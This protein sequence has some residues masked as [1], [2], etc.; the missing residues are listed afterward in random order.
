MTEDWL[1]LS[2]EDRW[3]ELRVLQKEYAR[4]PDFLYDVITGLMGFE[5]TPLQLDIALYLEFGPT[6]RMI[7][8]QRGQAKTTVTAAY[9]VWRLI[10]NPA[11]RILIVSAGDDM[12]TEIANW[13]IQIIMG[14]DEL[15]CMR[16]DRSHGD[17]ASVKAFDVH[18]VL[19][20]PEKS[21]SISCKGITSNLQG[22]RADILVAD[23]IESSKNSRTEL[24]REQLAHLTKDFS[25][26]C[27]TGDIIY[28]GTPQS[29]DSV[30]NGLASRGFDIRIWP[31]RYPTVQEQQNYGEFLA[32]IIKKAV[33]DDPSLRT[34]GGPLADR[35]QPT[36]PTLISEDVLTKK[37]IDQGKAYFQLQHMLDT[38]LMDKD[39][40]PLHPRNITFMHMTGNRMPMEINRIT[41]PEFRVFVPNDFPLQN[42][43]FFQAASFGSE[44]GEVSGTAMY[45]DPAGGG[46]NGDE[47]GF[48]VVQHLG[49]RVFVRQIGGFRGGYGEDERK[50]LTAIVLKWKPNVV[51]IERNYGNGAFAAIWMP[52][53]IRS[54]TA[55]GMQGTTIE[56]VWESGQKELRIID[57]LEPIVSSGKLIVD[58]DCLAQDQ[59]YCSE[60]PL[61]ERSVYSLF[62]QFAKITR[63]KNSLVHDDRLDALAGACRHF[64]EALSVDSIKEVER[65]R[66]DAY[67]RMVSDP[68]GNGRPV[69]N[70]RA[71]MGN[72]ISSLDRRKR[73]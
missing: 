16:P 68:F 72:S 66:Q 50:K 51:L 65:I 32:P 31:G 54:M 67:N 24:Q 33:E 56:E 45:V 40:Y 38:R 49:G 34:G 14:M 21:P 22:K 2:V 29:I 8:A 10:H 61:Q 47:I 70:Y 39:R 4:F 60:Y 15:R 5:C 27:S 1:D 44:F 36:D 35:G 11:A 7:Q 73:I 26:I 62:Y 37:E 28:L 6:Y 53:L 23:D 58:I 18:Y 42:A 19:K 69:A 25:S 71:L 48:A 43:Q 57:V 17:R 12:A 46:Q 64:V 55:S 59:K 52:E 13:V 3:A 30:Y 9:G 41:S 63:D 20:G